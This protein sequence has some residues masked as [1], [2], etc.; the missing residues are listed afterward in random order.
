MSY[1]KSP[2]QVVD[3]YKESIRRVDGLPGVNTTSFGMVA[4]W[5]DGGFG[6]SMQFSADGH[7]HVPNEDPRAH[8]RVV[9]PGFFATLPP[10]SR[11]SMLPHS[12]TSARRCSRRTV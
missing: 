5:R 8:M 1:G 3:F 11:L 12:K 2:Q 4:P 9:S 6:F 10:I 7:A